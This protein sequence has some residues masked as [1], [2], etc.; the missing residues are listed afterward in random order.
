MALYQQAGLYLAADLERIQDSPRISADPA[1]AAYLDRNLTFDGVLKVPEVT[2]H[3]TGDGLVVAANEAA[4]ADVVSSAAS[5]GQLRQ[6]FVHRANHCIFTPAEQISA[7]Q[8]LFDRLQTGTWDP[9]GSDV[10]NSRATA[11]GGQYNG[12]RLPGSAAPISAPAQFVD[13]TPPPFP[14]QFDSRNKLP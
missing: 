1:A 10:M 13:Y 11:L 9:T 6:L 2:L 12:G 14:R 3:T 7:F 4:Y 5:S 8:V